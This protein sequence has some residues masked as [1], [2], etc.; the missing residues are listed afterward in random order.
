MNID[1][2]QYENEMVTCIER[3][4]RRVM[5]EFSD[6]HFYAAALHEFYRESGDRISLPCLAVNTSEEVDDAGD[7]LWSSPDWYWV[8]LEFASKKL[9]QLH[10]SLECEANRR[11]TAHWDTVHTKWM[12]TLVRVAKQLTT[13]LKKN[14]AATNDFGFYLFD[15][16]G[17][18]VALLR[19]CM[20]AAKFKRLFPT[21]QEAI[22]EEAADAQ[23]PT[24]QRLA[25]YTND[26]CE[27]GEKLIKQGRSAVPILIGCLD[28]DQGWCAAG[29][30]AEL[31]VASN[32]VIR[33]LRHQACLQ[34]N[35]SPR[36]HFTSA[37]AVLGD[38]DFLLDIAKKADTRDAAIDGIK[39]LYG[40]GKNG[41]VPVSLDYSPLERLLSI[42]SCSKKA[43]RPCSGG[44]IQY[45]LSSRG[46]IHP[47]DTG[48]AI[49]GTTSRYKMIREH[50]ICALGDLSLIHI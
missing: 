13:R 15:W 36:F 29:L 27:Y 10:E 38:V 9:L 14:I 39:S 30:L 43:Q 16:D 42:K 28:S 44:P 31:G 49:A 3:A 46:A 7:S 45:A 17:D 47:E 22:D 48:T 20:S 40:S 32:E 34:E 12:N 23:R 2:K 50:A 11:T 18:E 33:A 19:R 41:F 24:K 37:L 35:E 6:E 25:K 21:L 8:D 1:F 5:V 4:V 26:L